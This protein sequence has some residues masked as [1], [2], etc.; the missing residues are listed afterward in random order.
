MADMPVWGVLSIKLA[1]AGL[2]AFLV[3]KYRKSLFKPLNVGM[4]LVVGVN[5]FWLITGVL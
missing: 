3:Y 4:G 2:F 1:L 5:L